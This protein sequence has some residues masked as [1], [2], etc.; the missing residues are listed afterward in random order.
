MA[1][2]IP[3][4][5]APRPIVAYEPKGY[6][7]KEIFQLL[8]SQDLFENLDFDP[9]YLPLLYT[10]NL[11]G[12]VMA[13]CIAQGPTGPVAIKATT[14]GTLFTVARG[15]AFSQ[16]LVLTGNATDAG[17]I[18]DLGQQVSRIDIFTYDNAANYKLSR[19]LVLPLGDTIELFKDSFY[20]LD[21][22]TRR[23][24]VQNKTALAV[25]RYRFI[26]WYD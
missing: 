14:D 10:S 5:K 2:P 22:Y 7:L 6:A 3:K 12:R 16:Y 17:A 20:S 13:R 24:W 26:G 15:G 4:K 21:V 9:K 23:I 1:K 25:A 19:D 18:V 11:I 8:R